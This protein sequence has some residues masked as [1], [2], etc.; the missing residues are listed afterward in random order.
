MVR[1]AIQLTIL[2]MLAQV[3][4]QPM[5]QNSSISL[6]V[7]LVSTTIMR[8]LRAGKIALSVR[9]AWHAHKALVLVL[10]AKIH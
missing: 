1:L 7:L 6:P 5:A 10:V 3:T 8:T 9:M 2:M 4:T